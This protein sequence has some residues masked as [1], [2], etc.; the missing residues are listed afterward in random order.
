M[1]VATI[2]LQDAGIRKAA[3]LVASLDQAAADLLLRQLGPERAAL[4]RQAVTYLDD[5]DADERQRIIDEFRR[6]GPMVPG[7][8][9]AGIELDRLPAR[10][11]GQTFLSAV[12]VRHGQTGMLSHR[13]RR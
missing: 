1:D 6:I 3:I 12:A 9:P 11:V 13:R 2:S 4:V 7:P 10:S 8:S 5:I